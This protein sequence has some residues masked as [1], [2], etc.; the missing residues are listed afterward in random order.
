MDNALI[1]GDTNRFR[2]THEPDGGW[3]GSLFNNGIKHK[4]INIL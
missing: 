1:E 3:I 2:E 4:S